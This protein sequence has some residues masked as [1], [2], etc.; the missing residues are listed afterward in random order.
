MKR[1]LKVGGYNDTA[2]LSDAVRANERLVQ[3]LSQI[4]ARLAELRTRFGQN[5]MN[6]EATLAV[7]IEN[8]ERL[9]G[10]GEDHRV[11]RAGVG[12]DQQRV[13]RVLEG[14]ADFVLAGMF[15]WQIAEDVKITKQALAK[16]KRKRPWRA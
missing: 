16:L 1:R 6:D 14:G 12:L 11:V 3:L 13:E 4:N 10:L 9:A 5:A 15:D 7:F 8:E 2:S